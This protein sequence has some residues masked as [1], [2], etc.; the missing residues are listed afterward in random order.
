M[1][2]PSKA[3]LQNFLSD[4]G[5]SEL[6]AGVQKLPRS[7][8]PAGRGPNTIPGVDNYGPTRSGSYSTPR[9]GYQS[10][11]DEYP[12][13]FG[14]SGSYMP[15]AMLPSSANPLMAR[16][17]HPGA[18][19]YGQPEKFDAWEKQYDLYQKDKMR[20]QDLDE[21][22]GPPPNPFGGGGGGYVRGV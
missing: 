1:F 22:I 8:Y 7:N 21:L 9:G 17:P 18:Y 20:Q 10:I 14:G 4:S 15:G 12:N 11:D 16:T 2:T 19:P 5:N 3:F 13:P 6:M